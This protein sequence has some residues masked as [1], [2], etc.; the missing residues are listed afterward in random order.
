MKRVLRAL[1]VGAGV[2]L[3]VL[4]IGPFII[5]VPP[6]KDTRPVE[7]LAEADSRFMEVEGVNLH[8]K[9]YGEGEPALILLHGFAASLFSWREVIQPLSRDH[10]VIAY[11]RPGFGLT[12]RP[13][14]W[15]GQNPYS[16][17]SQVDLLKGLMNQLGIER[18]VLIGNST[19]GAVAANAALRYPERVQALVLVNPAINTH[20]RFPA[21]VKPLLHTPQADHVGPLL[22]R[23]FKDLGI[24]LGQTAW[25][26]PSKITEEVWEGYLKPLQAENWDRGLWEFMAASQEP[27]TQINLG[28]LSLPILVITGDDDRVVPTEQSIQLA[29][30]LSNASLVNLPNCGHV[31]HEECPEPFLEA[32]TNFLNTVNPG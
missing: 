29:K 24:Q 8:F 4:L 9:M 21:W 23:R 10:L 22:T 2:L 3:G 15:T 27:R 19:G 1:A 6:L 12:E 18:A 16:P 32:I 28:N 31:P 7:E 14:E 25:H 11:D 20:N 30:N 5:P 13:L 17:E 26:D